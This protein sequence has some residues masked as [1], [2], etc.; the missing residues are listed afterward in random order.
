[1]KIKALIPIIVTCLVLALAYNFIAIAAIDAPH[2]E[3]NSVS[4]GSCHGQGLLQSPFW[5]GSMS[6]DELCQYCHTASSC[7]IPEITGPL[8]KTHSDSDESALAECRTCHDPHYQKQK[9]YKN[10]DASSLYLATGTIT[11]C[12]YNGDGTS[13][14]TYSSITYKTGWDA[15]K[16]IEKTD[17]CRHAIMFPNVKKLGYSYPII[18]VDTPT[19]DTITVKGD[20]T[21]VYQYIT[22]ST[23]AVMYGQ[24]IRDYI[25][26]K[27]VKFFDKTGSNSYAD[28][29]GAYN[30]VCEVCHTLTDHYRNDGS[31]P[32]QSHENLGGKDGTNC[33]TCHVHPG[34]FAHGGGGGTECADCHGTTGSHPAHDVGTIGCDPCHN[35]DPPNVSPGAGYSFT[36][37]DATNTCFNVRSDTLG[38]CHFETDATWDAS[39]CISCHGS[40]HDVGSRVNVMAQLT[41]NS[42]HIQDTT[43]GGVHCYECHW[44]ADDSGKITSYHESDT[45]GSKV[46]L[47]KYGAGARPVTYTPG[48]TA[49]EY[50]ADGSRAEFAK[51]NDHC[52]SCHSD[53]NNSTQPFADGKT[54]KEYAWDNSSI[55][56]RY[57]QAGSTT[58]GKYDP[59]SKPDVNPKYNRTKTYSAH[60]NA[61]NNQGGWD[62]DEGW[63]NNRNGSVN[64]LCFDCHN[65]HGSTVFGPTTSYT[66][67]TTAGG[68]LK[69][70][71]AGKGGYSVGYKPVAGGSTDD[72]NA[73]KAGAGLC[74][75]CHMNATPEGTKPWGYSDTFGA[76]QEIIGYFD[77]PYFGPSLSGPQKRSGYKRGAAHKGGHFGAS[78]SLSTGVSG[79]INGLCTPCHDPHGVSTTLDQAYSVPLLKGT[80]M[81]SFYN[82]DRAPAGTTQTRWGAFYPYPQRD[83]YRGGSTPGY[84]VDQNSLA[85]W[86]W[87]SGQRLSESDSQ[88]AGLCIQCHAKNSID[89]DS[90]TTW[91]SMDRI[92]ET[93]KGWGANLKHSFSCSKCHTPH[94]SRLPRLMITS[95]LE[96][97]HRGRVGSGGY[98]GRNYDGGD[99]GE[100]GG[101]FPAGGRQTQCTPP[102]DC[103]P[104]NPVFYFGRTVCHRDVNTETD[105][106]PERELWN[107]VTLWEGL[108]ITSGP[109]VSAAPVGSEIQTTVTWST[110]APST[111]Y[112]DYGLT[113]DYDSTIGSDTLVTNHSVVLPG[114]PN[115]STYHYRIRSQGDTETATD[116]RTFDISIPPYVPVLVDEPYNTSTIVTLEWNASINPGGAGPV[117]Y[118]VQVKTGSIPWADAEFK[119]GWITGTSWQITVGFNTTWYWRVR[120]RD[121]TTGSASGWSAADS[122][123]VVP[124]DSPP[125]APTIIDEP[126]FDGG[127]TPTLVTLE[128]IPE[129]D[130]DGHPVE[131]YVEVDD[132]LDFSS[133][134][135]SGWISATS[136]D[137]TVGTCTE[138]WWRVK[139]RDATD[140]LESGWST[141]DEF[142]DALG[143][144]CLAYF[145]PTV[146][147]IIDEPDLLCGWSSCPV[148]LEWNA[149]TSTGYGTIEYKVYIVG[150]SSGWITG[151][152]YTTPSIPRDNDKTR[153]WSVKARLSRH[154][155]ATSAYSISD[156]FRVVIPADY[157]TL[158][159]TIPLPI[160]EP[161]HVCTEPCP[162]TLEWYASTNPNG[163]GVQYQIWVDDDIG[164]GS[165]EFNSGWFSGVSHEFTIRPY[166]DVN[167][168]WKIRA[169]DAV[170]L[171]QTGWSDVDS[172]KVEQ[173][174]DSPPLAPILIAEPDFNGAVTL[175][176]EWNPEPDPDGHSVE[177]YV[178]V[179]DNSD[180]SS[181]DFVENWDADTSFD[182]TVASCTEWFW[183]VKAR[184]ASDLAES[185]SW[186]GSDFFVDV[187]GSCTGYFTPSVPVLI[188][189]PNTN[190]TSVTLEWNPSTGN[191]NG[192]YEYKVHVDDSA[193]FSSVDY[194]SGWITGTSWTF[195]SSNNIKWYWRVR[196]RDPNHSSTGGSG[197]GIPIIRARQQ[198]GLILISSGYYH[199]VLR[200][201][202]RY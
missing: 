28:G 49:I 173:P 20:A 119:S 61:L 199:L 153:W 144:D 98:P 201:L 127:G 88:F 145:A 106:F 159:P 47:V 183:R 196:A 136:F 51:L 55:D 24:Y 92:H 52:I 17:T 189:E 5:G 40:T 11:G 90:T 102:E 16:L 197:H 12:V 69:D 93:V 54:P 110:D 29:V 100:G 163:N 96:Y 23:Y 75:D 140:L 202:L 179:D 160:L 53:Q 141:T 124:P 162:V 85:D 139:A 114:L 59:A 120:A 36:Y 46:D 6:I 50:T 111:S 74:F 176:L 142:A 62:L 80:W 67:A 123:M 200:R 171:D 78:S 193:S 137:I 126:D 97:Q 72:K 64:V 187:S 118:W 155:D 105:T 1:M 66:S 14:L 101:K 122:F 82:E 87:G 89:P 56:E 190:S 156:S 84:Y 32:E 166:K 134:A 83:K 161:D 167:M 104:Y 7:P 129:V 39:G 2:N 27:P 41:G 150:Y 65:S 91:K 25:N 94:S 108:K 99:Y 22:E 4:C 180:F 19:A 48:A 60:G 73:Y 195:T 148:T 18:A 81:T 191:G 132:V 194:D 128:W 149:S 184:D 26:D 113:T 131:Y 71:V 116:D 42:H 76:S 138:W 21:P 44:E 178:E 107:T 186:S 170:T 3:A 181:P 121:A 95:C 103:P 174:P 35:G 8:V 188:D 125:L 117:E 112:V 198:H 68:I 15:T 130:P 157:P 37:D 152:S 147:V 79:S 45:P 182:I 115:H 13:T 63:P 34:S 172:F 168:Y 185:L 164:F 135:T 38:S 10:T 109:S 86:A 30:G 133:P 57:S 77:T 165:L 43:V 146:P 175:T 31:A 169:R 58:W 70:T 143:A 154:P 151:T 33:I 158:P 9:N 177:Y 192:P